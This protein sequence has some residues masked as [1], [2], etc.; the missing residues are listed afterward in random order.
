MLNTVIPARIL[1]MTL[2]NLN[3]AIAFQSV[4][5]TTESCKCFQINLSFEDMGSF[6]THD[7]AIENTVLLSPFSGKIQHD[8]EYVAALG[9]SQKANFVNK[10]DLQFSAL[11]IRL[12]T[13]LSWLYDIQSIILQ[14]V[15]LLFPKQG[16]PYVDSDA[17][18]KNTPRSGAGGSDLLATIS[19]RLVSAD[20][21]IRTSL[22]DVLVTISAPNAYL[23]LFQCKVSKINL[24]FES[25][26]SFRLV[27]TAFP[28]FY[29][30]DH[31][32]LSMRSVL[33]VFD[34]A[35]SW[36]S[37]V[38][39]PSLSSSQS[40]PSSPTSY[41][42]VR[43]IHAAEEESGSNINNIKYNPASL[44]SLLVTTSC[45]LNFNISPAL[46][47]SLIVLCTS[48]AS[49]FNAVPYKP[50]IDSSPYLVV[51]NQTGEH[52]LVAFYGNLLKEDG[53]REVKE[54]VVD[55]EVKTLLT[56]QEAFQE[57]ALSSTS[58]SSS[59]GSSTSIS[60][61]AGKSLRLRMNGKVY[62]CFRFESYCN[63]FVLTVY[64]FHRR[65]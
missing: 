46:L 24:S 1:S 55:E 37:L 60:T 4:Q 3:L 35:L 51:M 50:A 18:S 6:I 8:F 2:S 44:G 12:E 48:F 41:R 34:L 38:A 20:I 49:A 65:F 27:I 57:L 36:S 53:G 15:I 29:F 30:H 23:S 22:S 25:S 59:S 16:R 31:Q 58:L 5:D 11:A 10:M 39:S 56:C 42:A 47:R 40:P 21:V 9:M 19:D 17:V 63:V 64:A 52:I 28:S 45:K 26:I 14:P 54:S 33:N 7:G 43:L 13:E 32:A 62:K 61:L